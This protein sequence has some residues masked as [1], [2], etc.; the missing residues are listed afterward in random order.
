MKIIS[1]NHRVKIIIKETIPGI[2]NATEIAIK[3]SK[4]FCTFMLEV[5]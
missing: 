3:G 4:Y 1:S 5:L 2:S